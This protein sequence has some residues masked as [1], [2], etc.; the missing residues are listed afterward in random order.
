[1]VASAHVRV[2]LIGVGLT[3]LLHA[4]AL[5]QSGPTTDQT[6]VNLSTTQALRRHGYYFRLTHRFARDLRRGGLGELAS[7][8]FGL[9]NGAIIGLD[10][11]YAPF[12]NAQVGVYRSL[13]LRTIQI[14]GRYDG[15][16]QSESMPISLSAA[17]SV[18]GVD[19]M[20]D[21]HSPSFGAVASRTMGRVALYLS[22]TVVFHSGTPS[23]TTNIGHD[24]GLPATPGAPPQTHD[25]DTF[26]AGIGGRLRVRPSVSLVAEVAPR[27][28]G[29]A[30]GRAA[31]GVA[32]EK[33]TRGGHA[34]QLTF[35][36]TFGTTVG[37]T[38]RGGDPH[39]VYLGFN[40]SRRF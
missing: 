35:T 38:A 26:F 12:T 11:R 33:V 37:Q 18:E 2:L 40:L 29:F 16:K 22:P 7:D 31:W 14:S 39:N 27:L 1:M 32:V 13:L 30:P 15:W 21:H 24:H 17:L 23:L 9:D 4:P 6:T 5:A 36:N 28:A 20:R 10:F 8:L 25:E 3:A 34:F 19:N